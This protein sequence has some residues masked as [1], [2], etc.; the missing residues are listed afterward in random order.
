MK[1]KLI[2]MSSLFILNGCQVTAPLMKNNIT[3][4]VGPSDFEHSFVFKNNWPLCGN[5]YDSDGNMPV[6]RKTKYLTTDNTCKVEPEGYVPEQIIIE[7]APWL[8]Y[9][10]RVKAG[11]GNTRSFFHLDELSRDKWPSDE[12]L[13]AYAD[14]V[15]RKIMTTIDNLPSTAWKRIVLTPPKEVEKYRYQVPEGKGNARRGKEIHYTISLKPDGSSS[16]ETK[17]YWVQKYQLNWN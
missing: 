11:L 9:E 10:E 1:I 14:D 8:T 16:I 4:V 17:L 5:F 13:H 15:A 7:Y 12:V 3:F 2:I 6:K